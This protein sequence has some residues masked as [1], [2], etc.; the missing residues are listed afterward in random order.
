VQRQR[1]NNNNPNPNNNNNNQ[2]VANNNNARLSPNPRNL[3]TLWQEYEFGF[4]GRKPAKDFTA[5][6]RGRVKYSYHRRKV[7][8]DKIAE[9]VRAGHTAQVAID[10]IYQVYGQASTVTSIINQMRQDRRTGGHPQLH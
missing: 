5:E 6:E 2:Q 1:A 8:W 7:V 9:L 3:H 4:G 10:R